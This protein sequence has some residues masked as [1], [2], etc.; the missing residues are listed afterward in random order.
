VFELLYLVEK[1]A[2]ALHRFAG[3]QVFIAAS[4]EVN[5]LENNVDGGGVE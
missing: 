1:V 2:G 3:P 4:Q 5:A